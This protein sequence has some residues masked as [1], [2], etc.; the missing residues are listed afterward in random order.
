VDV[1]LK[2]ADDLSKLP[3]P[4]LRDRLEG[5]F[6]ANKRRMRQSYKSYLPGSPKSP[7]F[8]RHRYPVITTGEVGTRLARFQ[9]VLG[10]AGQLSVEQIYDKFFRISS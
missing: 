10:D 2:I 3:K 1:L 8:L 6:K 9:Q 5:W 7:E 4:P